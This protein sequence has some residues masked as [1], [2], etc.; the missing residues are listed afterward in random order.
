MKIGIILTTDERSK[1]YL[2]KIISNKISIDE[3]ILMNEGAHSKDYSQECIN[4]AKKCGFDISKPTK[5][6]LNEH[7]M[8]FKEFNFNDINHIELIEYIR[9]KNFDFV[10][11]TG[12]GILRKG[13]LSS[14]TKFVHFHP[15][16]VPEYRGSTCFYYSMIKENNCGVTAF[17]MNEGLD[18]GDVIYQKIFE[19]P[20][21]VFIDDVYDSFIR[22]ETMVDVL[23]N[24]Q[25][26]KKFKKQDQTSGN[27][28]Y[29][30]HPVLKHISILSCIR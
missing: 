12:G 17:I 4:E 2:Q 6:T 10:I 1:A 26:E 28:F 21:H 5:E 16:I 7:K 22:S 11:F 13:I 8:K 27:T 23:K 15:G 14:G 19:K 24:N 29:I 18:T 3:I 20:N 9:K 25:L 30:I